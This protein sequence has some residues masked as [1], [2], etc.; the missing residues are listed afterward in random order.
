[1]SD[2]VIDCPVKTMPSADGCGHTV[3]PMANTMATQVAASG[4]RPRFDVA[5]ISCS[6]RIREPEHVGTGV[7]DRFASRHHGTAPAVARCRDLLVSAR[8]ALLKA[9]A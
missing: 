6:P 8:A 7:K 9:P 4:S 1:M 3:V 2:R 5:S